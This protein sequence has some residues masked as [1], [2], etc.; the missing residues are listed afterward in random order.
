MKFY[1]NQLNPSTHAM[2]N[3]RRLACV[4][5]KPLGLLDR[6]FS[7]LLIA[8]LLI[9]QPAAVVRVLAQEAPPPGV[10]PSV[11]PGQ[12]PR[13]FV[14]T[15]QADY[16]PGATANIVGRDFQAGETVWLQVTHADGTPDS[17]A[18][19]EPWAVLAGTDGAFQS[20]W[21]VCEDDCLGATMLLTATG[22]SSRLVAQM[23]FTDG[24]PSGISPIPGSLYG[25]GYNYYGQLGTGDNFYR[26]TPT[27]VVSLPGGRKVIAVAGG[28]IHSLAQAND[29]SL[30]A[31]GYGGNGQIGNNTFSTTYVPVPVSALPDGRTAISIAAGELHNLVLANDGSLWAW[32]YGAD[33]ELGYGGSTTIPYP[34]QVATLGDGRTVVQIAAGGFHNLALANDGSLWAWGFNGFGQL[35]NNYSAPAYAPWAVIPLPG[36]RVVAKIA[37]GYYHSLAL[38]TDGTI[39]AWGNGANGQLGNGG[40]GNA[41]TPVAVNPL[42]GGR[43]PVAIAAGFYHS[44]ALASDGTV[45]AWGY[46]FNGELGN[47]LSSGAYGPVAVNTLPSGRIVQTIAASGF[48]NYALATDGSM[49]AWGFGGSGQLGNGSTVN[50]YWPVAV[51]SLPAGKSILR[52]ASGAYAHGFILASDGNQAPVAAS[53]S[54]TVSEDI[55]L[56][57]AAPGVL[58]DDTDAESQPLTASLSVAPANAAAF[59]LNAN[60][61]FTY[62]PTANFH[63][64]DSFTYRAFDGTDYSLPA[65][66]TIN[67]TPVN[68]APL[69]ITLSNV[70]VAENLPAGT[71]VGTINVIDPD[72][73][74]S[75]TFVQVAHSPP[76]SLNAANTYFLLDGN[77]VRTAQVFDFEAA[78]SRPIRIRATDAGGLSADATF[79][80]A[81]L[82]VNETPVAANDGYN[83]GE[84]MILSLASAANG[85]L[86][87][88]SDADGNPLTA[89]LVSGP[90][91]GSLTLNSDGRFT[92]TPVANFNGPDTFTYKANDGTVDSGVATVT[93]NVNPANDPPVTSSQHL[94]TPE[95]VALAVVLGATDVD[96]DVV[97]LSVISG[98]S[99]G[100]VSGEVPDLTYTPEANF[101][102]SDFFGFLADDGH[103][104][105]VSATVY[106]TVT[107]VNDVPVAVDNSYNLG[108][109]MILSPIT[110]AVGILANDTDAD[111][112]TLSAI[113]VSGPAHGTLTLQPDGRFTYTPTA[114]FNGSDTFTYKVSDGT[115]ESAVAT[116]TINVNPANDA[117]VATAQSVTTAEDT[118]VAV[119]LSGSDVD[120][121]GLSYIVVTSPAHGTLSGIAPNL[122]YRP[123][124]NYYGPDQFSFRV[125]DGLANSEVATVSI[126]VT[127]VN[128]FP[129]A[130]AQSVVTAE[131]TATAITL[132]ASD[133]EAGGYTVLHTLTGN[134]GRESYGQLIEG[135]GGFLYGT[136]RLGGASERGVVFRVAKDG[137]GYTV[138]RAFAGADGDQPNSGLTRGS[139]GLLYG[140]TVQGGSVNGG[141][142]YR[143][144]GDGSQFAVLRHF[145]F[146][147]GGAYAPF[148]GV[149]EGADGLLYGTTR[150]GGSGSVGTI[151]RLRRD[152]SDFTVLHAL[153]ADGSRGSYL[154]AGLVEGSANQ[155]FGVAEAGGTAGAGVVFRVNH[156]G[157]GFIVL[158]HFGVI[159]G[160]GQ[161]PVADLMVGPDGDLYGTTFAGGAS[162]NGTVFRINPDGT[163]YRVLRAFSDTYVDARHPERGALALG[164]DGM[165]YGST[166]ASGR[167]G[168]VYRIS[169]SGSHYELLHDAQMNSGDG[170]QSRTGVHVDLNGHVFGITSRGGPTDQGVLFRLNPA[171]GGIVSYLVTTQPQHGTLAGTPP[172][173]VYT[174]AANYS[175]TDRFTFQVSDGSLGSSVWVNITVLPM[176]DAPVLAGS[177]GD[178]AG[179]YGT[180]FSRTL[181][182]DIFMDVDFGSVLTYAVSGLPAGL[183]FDSATRTIAGIPAAAG[184]STVTITATDNAVPALSASTTYQLPI[185]KATPV[186]TWAAQAD[187]NCHTVLGSVQLNA[188]A[189]APGTF[190]YNPPAGA[191]LPLGDG[192][193]LSV[194]FAPAD[195]A[196][197]NPGAT[198]TTVNVRLTAG[199]PPGQLDLSFDTGSGVEGYQLRKIAVQADG[200]AVI[201]GW[202]TAINGVNRNEIARLNTDGSLD[203]SFNPGSG[204]S[205]G[206]I[207]A[208]AV[209]T[210][211]KVLIS[212]D[213]SAI[214]GVSRRGVARL[215][216]DGSVD[217]SFNPGTGADSRVPV[218]AV[219]ADGK[220]LLGG[221]FT[222]VNGVSRN[223]IARLNSDG[224]VDTSF[225]PGA[226]PVWSN[227]NYVWCV[228]VQ[229]DGKVLIG[230]GLTSFNG[231]S[232]NRIARL[233]SDGSLDSSF[234]VGSGAN[235]EV[236]AVAMQSDGKVLIGGTFTSV[237]GLSRSRLARLNVDGSVDVGFSPNVAGPV[238]SVAVQSDGRVLIGGNMGSVNGV[239]RMRVARI[240]ANGT[241][242]LSFDPGSGP[243]NQVRSLA[244]QSDG[245]VLVGGDF[246]TINGVARARI[247]RLEGESFAPMVTLNGPASMSI[248]ASET[249]TDPGASAA[250]ACGGA[251]PV[252]V[253][254]TV[255]VLTPGNY[256]VTYSAVDSAGQTVSVTRSITVT[257]SNHAPVANAQSVTTLEDTAASVTLAGSDVD[258]GAMSFSVVTSPAHGILSGTAPNLTYTPAPDY[259]GQDSF[260]FTVSD[261]LAVSTFAAVNITVTDVLM[262]LASISP[263]SATANGSDFWLTVAGSNFEPDT[264]VY[265]NGSARP[266]T[267]A[268]PTQVT[269]QIP[270]S[271]L[272]NVTD[273]QT[274]NVTVGEPTG[275]ESGVA[276]FAIVPASVGEVQAS[277]VPAGESGAV[278]SPPTSSTEPGVSVAIQNNG[279]GSVTTVAATYDTRPTGQTVF[280]VDSGSFVDVQFTGADSADVA[281]VNFY[282]P[283]SITG[284][285]E[286]S[287]KLR[288]FD[289]ANWI[290]VL[291][292][293]GVVPPKNTTDNLDGTISG[294]RFTVTFDNTSTPKIT[295]LN[296]TIFG[297]IDPAP[298]VLTVSG[299]TGPLALGT[300]ASVSVTYATPDPAQVCQVTFAWDDGST[301]VVTGNNGTASATHQYATAG[302]YGVPVTV[303]DADGAQGTATFEYVVIYDPSAGFVTGG[304]WINSPV[305]AY[306][307]DLA[308]TGKA[309]FGFVSKYQKGANVPTGNT[310]FQFK[311]GNLNFSSTAYQWLVV[312]GAKAQYKGDGTINGTGS[313]GFLLT[314][315]D[316]QISGGGGVDKFR[317][318][319]WTKATGA[320][321]YDN[322]L[323]SSDDINSANPQALGGGSIV[324]QKAK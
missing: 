276:I 281:L 42:P 292:S 305:G 266:T 321:V 279:G 298:Q 132:G 3:P 125:S 171:A 289:G 224:S 83:L 113:L 48:H 31:W 101:H 94:S 29:G 173:L 72:V 270:T 67:V 230:G 39:W 19:H 96:G 98:P 236:Y 30:W 288:Y 102:G 111:G 268:S 225:D 259:H 243:D 150:A 36:G 103:G 203:L 194:T 229:P 140:T 127:P 200:K 271:D 33:G 9:G 166:R 192:Q 190:T 323:G 144:A 205:G 294:G 217:S 209:Q 37:A 247:A 221:W 286:N 188:A 55:A 158:H 313:Y 32:G 8:L 265:W 115:T 238:F 242:D 319:I 239:I 318:K 291:S 69:N 187:I 153:P 87:N 18:D 245:K 22:Q 137:T 297:M 197:W 147:S 303:T 6:L 114:N 157:S 120:G 60:G 63:G 82:N 27:P 155:W 75:H 134:D 70:S 168:A 51:N 86:A 10:P 185:A 57:V 285:Q 117:P 307:P 184:T 40:T 41:Y 320:V 154:T 25:M 128:D 12:V 309:T 249:F 119:P 306:V 311:A 299:P 314:A 148:A 182:A 93:I 126:T 189:N 254:S 89:L 199:A 76:E 252:T 97:S 223:R 104:G 231:V 73:G 290:Q 170:I 255:D 167:F 79:S 14:G 227:D 250:D 302:V 195:P 130:Y 175:G 204:P 308:L 267:Y 4:K 146:A 233:N 26:T 133:P 262:G 24:T 161:S 118:A 324:I 143:M 258:G 248:V 178:Q 191:T 90:V 43:V 256:T 53:D 44:L 269:A 263:A 237:N 180:A 172:N 92:Y 135:D 282:Y 122:T 214:N 232:Q 78:S 99:H 15:D 213:F 287:V 163:G 240:H 193:M 52:I 121:D 310:E 61:S 123:F 278:S 275:P 110:P 108:E 50:A 160:D 20:A 241:V 222:S 261:G 228:A 208:V 107:P 304:G 201:C 215:N 59:A 46:G 81:I 165:L 156:D 84:D 162:G 181:A 152:G 112:D 91:H 300:S 216:Q 85:V 106:L 13:P 54:F 264:V 198:T 206:G 273:I 64:A 211:G 235:Q 177:V 136:T 226:G 77:L 105:R 149:R 124:Y 202:F 65:T 129:E 1:S 100:S 116:V 38:A 312:A 220:V 68:D 2:K 274:V 251:I 317:I 280:K 301:T 284:G 151:Y 17:G 145:T 35:G 186:I 11:A 295:E 169:P 272:A 159:A 16:P 293:G 244:L 71:V 316:G 23:Q 196:N 322:A 7:T 88:D 234:N 74:D 164:P 34:I 138:L 219:Q 21:H 47:A 212:G 207:D 296:G 5:L 49:W 80:I 62:T 141:V 176:N 95:D 260:T 174:P 257:P 183:S 277:V 142:I 253:S 131:D 45:W 218:V 66:V 28:E 210:D 283:A 58:G 56:S 139:D 109:D 315:T 246:T 179:V